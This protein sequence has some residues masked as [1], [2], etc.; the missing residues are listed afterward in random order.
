[1]RNIYI[2]LLTVLLTCPIVLPPLTS[3]SRAALSGPRIYIDPSDNIFYSNVTSVG[4]CFNVTVWVENAPDLGGAQVNLY[5]NDTIINV[6]RWWAPS[7]DS[8]FFMPAPITTLPPP[9]NPGYIHVGPGNGYVKIAVSKAGYPPVAPWGHNGTICIFEFNITALPPDGGQLSCALHINTATTFLLDPNAEQ[10]L[11]VIKEDGTYTFNYGAA[12]YLPHIW[13]EALPATYEATK[14]RPFNVSVLIQNV[15]QTDCL[16]GI[17]L[18]V[19]YNSTCLEVAEVISGDFMNKSIWAPNNAKLLHYVDERGV[20]CGQMILP[21]ATGEWNPP[22]PEGNGTVVTITFLPLLHEE[23]NFNIT[24]NPLFD[25][26]FL[27]KEGEEIPYLSAKHC[28]YVYSPLPLPTLAIT[29][30]KYTASHVGETF[31]VNVTLNNLDAQWDMTYAE[32]KLRYDN[33]TLQVSNVV[34]GDFLSQFGNTTFNHTEVDGYIKMN[35]TLTP[36]TYPYG[37]GT[38]A[39]ITFNVTTSPGLSILSLNDTKLLDFETKEVLHEVQHG[40]Y[41]LHEI[42]VHPIVWNTETFDI[43]TVSNTSV[44]PVPMIFDQPHMLLYFNVTGYNSTIGFVNITI[45]RDLLS[46]SPSDWFVIVNGEKVE[47]TLVENATHVSLY[48][49]F[50]SSST[51]VYVLGTSVIPEMPPNILILVLLAAT[52]MGL[53]VAKKAR[54]KKHEEL[55]HCKTS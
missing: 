35:I 9:P 23:T 17:Q 26:F 12:P 33:K 15:S 43:V 20:I 48:F 6:T 42:L 47:V 30:S 45:P 27:N 52:L 34:E 54:L 13:L 14:L 51:T 44:T 19:G 46:S 29:P 18:I 49:T 10:I 8:S 22:F 5:F 39:T 40:Y 53:A 25:W 37:N 11:D 41:Q 32:F 28:Q 24:I 38:L 1:M 50:S 3:E 4:H 21:N 31:D 16:I 55:V 36:T 2:I 7:W